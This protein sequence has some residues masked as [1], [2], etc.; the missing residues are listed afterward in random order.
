MEPAP[1]PTASCAPRPPDIPDYP[2][3]FLDE[4][5]V[6]VDEPLV[7]KPLEPTDDIPVPPLHPH[8]IKPEEPIVPEVVIVQEE[9]KPEESTELTGNLEDEEALKPPSKDLP[10]FVFDDYESVRKHRFLASISVFRDFTKIFILFS[11]VE[12]LTK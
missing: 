10:A 2:D 3:I 5:G 7:D 8:P 11:A 12:A 1:S 6:V 4:D 9:K